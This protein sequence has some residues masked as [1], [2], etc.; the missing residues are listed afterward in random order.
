MSSIQVAGR[1][2]VRQPRIGKMAEVGREFEVCAHKELNCADVFQINAIGE[3]QFRQFAEK[4][5][6]DMLQRCPAVEF[7]LRDFVAIIGHQF[8]KVRASGKI[9]RRKNLCVPHSQI[10]KGVGCDRE[11]CAVED[12]RDPDITQHIAVSEVKFLEIVHLAC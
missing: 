12:I 6:F 1:I 11:L 4:I 3:V 2:Q 9:E 5:D 10:I 8:T 7:Q